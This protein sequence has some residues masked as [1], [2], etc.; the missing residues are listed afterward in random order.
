VTQESLVEALLHA[1]ATSPDRTAIRAGGTAWTYADL[2]DRSGRIG[3]SLLGR[4]GLRPGDRIGILGQNDPGYLAAY[5][6]ILRAGCVAVPLNQFLLAVELADQLELVG[7]RL[8]LVGRIDAATAGTVAGRLPTALI[9]DLFGGTDRSLPPV[10]AQADATILLTSGTT[11]SPKGAVQTHATMRF[12]IS[13]LH[14]ALPFSADDVMLAFLPFFAALPEQILPTLLAGGTLEVLPRFDLDAVDEACSRVTT[15]DA[16]PTIMAR[17][18]HG[19]DH[20]RLARLRWL[21][22]ASEPM[23]PALLA[24]WWEAL[25]AVRTYEFYG[26]TEMLTITVATPETLRAAPDSV[27]LPFPGSAVSVVDPAG[28]PVL[29]G[30]PGEVVCSSPARMRG[31]MPDGIDPA[32][33]RLPSGAMRTGDLGRFDEGGRLVLTGRIKDL[34]ISGGLNIAPAEIE[35]V[36]VTHPAVAGAVVVGIPDR[37]WGE[38]P[39]VIAVAKRDASLTPDELLAYCRERLAS[40]KRPTGAALV[41]RFPMTGIGKSSKAALRDEILSGALEIVRAR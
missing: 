1:V 40:Y 12:A 32:T 16:V 28:G 38:T 17:L 11:G 23:P 18:L 22:F 5:F 15:F 8:C 36:A 21:M 27:G 41:E 29:V 3:A 20:A 10:E 6:G 13:E 7:A 31:Y 35:A 26:M 19:I 9:D 25:P 24:S 39:I 37:R 33:W 4:F 14:R 34:I 30:E 2:W